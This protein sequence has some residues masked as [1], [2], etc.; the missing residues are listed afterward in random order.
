MKV[1]VRKGMTEE[2]LGVG[3]PGD[4][5]GGAPGGVS[6]LALKAVGENVLVS[7]EGNAEC[8]AG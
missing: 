3:G 4:S 5:V 1:D 8:V 7:A 2:E 6:N